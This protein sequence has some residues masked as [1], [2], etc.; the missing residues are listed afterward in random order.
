MDDPSSVA[1]LSHL[2]A[3]ALLLEQEHHRRWTFAIAA[4][5]P[6]LALVGFAAV[7]ARAAVTATA[8]AAVA[9]CALAW[10]WHL[11]RDRGRDGRVRRAWRAWLAATS[12]HESAAALVD[13][14]LAYH[15][16]RVA[17]SDASF[18]LA[19]RDLASLRVMAL[20]GK[21][22]EPDA[23]YEAVHAAAL[24][25]LSARREAATA[26][27]VLLDAQ[28]Q[29]EA[30]LAVA[31]EDR[32]EILR[33]AS[34]TAADFLA[35]VARGELPGAP[36]DAPTLPLDARE[37]ELRRLFERA[38]REAARGKVRESPAAGE[39]L[40]HPGRWAAYSPPKPVSEALLALFDPTCAAFP[41]LAPRPKEP[42]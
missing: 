35:A 36:I 11:W 4:T 40:T 7:A 31:E 10:G 26:E 22:A 23:L 34:Q 8:A 21:L 16:L 18:D 27:G 13:V 3:R 24:A 30:I 6:A 38:A 28:R 1:H 25:E 42:S 2:E 32:K 39:I 9:A 12:W 14:F 41:P 20:E 17:A 33:R 19:V 29:A 15:P 37:L 5:V